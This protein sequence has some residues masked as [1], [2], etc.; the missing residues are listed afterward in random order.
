M[1]IVMR[2]HHLCTMGDCTLSQDSMVQSRTQQLTLVTH[3]ALFSPP[4]VEIINRGAN[5]LWAREVCWLLCYYLI[6]SD[7]SKSIWLNL[8]HQTI[9]NLP[10][11]PFQMS[12]CVHSQ[13]KFMCK[14]RITASQL[15]TSSIQS[16]CSLQQFRSHICRKDYEGRKVFSVF[17]FF[18]LV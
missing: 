9:W 6:L 15:N 1:I 12:P 3:S 17:F 16:G 5:A 18:F 11:V 8:L 4:D 7:H 13:I 2:I 10:N 14:T